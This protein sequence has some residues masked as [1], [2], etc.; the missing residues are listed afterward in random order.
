MKAALPQQQA[1]AVQLPKEVLSF[2]ELV[3]RDR[4]MS[5]IDKLLKART[6]LCSPSGARI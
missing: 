1:E 6:L 3:R 2:E 4:E 5:P